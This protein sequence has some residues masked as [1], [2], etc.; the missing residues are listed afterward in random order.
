MPCA[1]CT[2]YSADCAGACGLAVGL[3]QGADQVVECRSCLGVAR[4]ADGRGV[5][6]FHLAENDERLLVRALTLWRE[7]DEPC[8]SVGRIVLSLDVAARL[9]LVDEFT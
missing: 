3:L 2:T 9:D 4:G 6:T 1:H 8:P 5:V 7:N